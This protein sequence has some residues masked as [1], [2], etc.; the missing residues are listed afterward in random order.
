MP[1]ATNNAPDPFT[2]MSDNFAAL[3]LNNE[4]AKLENN[5]IIDN[6]GFDFG[7]AP[8]NDPGVGSG[9]DIFGDN[10]NQDKTENS[11]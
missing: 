3:G 1:A 2:D 6:T 8:A 5:A 7:G 10:T 11:K 9:N 4:P